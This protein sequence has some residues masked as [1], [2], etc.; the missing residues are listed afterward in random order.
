MSLIGRFFGY[1]R[2]DPD[3][4]DHRF[5]LSHPHASEVELPMAADL[6]K[7]LP[8]AVHQQSLGSCT[9][10][11][12][13]AMMAYLY[14][15]FDPS[16]LALYYDTRAREG[17][18][19]RDNGCQIRNA[20][21]TLQ[22]G[23]AISEEDWPYDIDRY[24]ESPPAD[25]SPRHTIAAYSRLASENEMLSCLALRQPFVLAITL[26]ATFEREVGLHGIMPL[27]TG[28]P[29]MIGSHAM[30]CVGYD[31]EFHD[32]PVLAESGVDPASVESSAL[33]VRN[34]WGPFWG[35]R[36]IPGHAYIPLSWVA[37][38]STGGDCW[39]GHKL[40]TTAS[41]PQG[42]TVA[43]VPIKGHRT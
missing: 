27:P 1:L 18:I 38:P 40:F 8:P 9:A 42:P 29:D 34:S 5:L 10:Q 19:A 23:G 21:K 15:G 35:A 16:P 22:K 17:T 24:A 36:A 20:M 28:K 6:H 3:P 37:N 43:G 30:L 2:D 41:E 4:R 26:P 32:N 25:A 33:L 31:L 14:P 12:S 39:T 13:A 11:A 7:R